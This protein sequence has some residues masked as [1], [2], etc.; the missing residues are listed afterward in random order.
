M[1][2]ED[3][4]DL[5]ISSKMQDK[6]QRLIRKSRRGRWM[7]DYMLRIDTSGQPPYKKRV[8]SL[9]LNNVEG[10]TIYTKNG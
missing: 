7:V 9:G 2:L 5:Q 8:I 1:T 3:L 6:K 4:K 10:R